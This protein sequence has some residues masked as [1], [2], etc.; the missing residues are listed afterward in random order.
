MKALVYFVFAFETAQTAMTGADMYVWFASGFG[1]LQGLANSGLSPIDIPFFVAF[2][3][4]VVQLFFAYR[5]YTIRNSF[6]PAVI[7]IILLSIMQAGGGFCTGIL[8]RL[9]QEFSASATHSTQVSAGIWLGGTA[10]VDVIIA[11]TMTYLL[12]SARKQE[13]HVS[14][15]ILT[16]IVRLTVETNTVTAI[17]SII[18]IG[19]EYGLPNQPYFYT[20]TAVLGKLYSNT[21]LVTLNN[22]AALRNLRARTP[23]VAARVM[24]GSG[25]TLQGSRSTEGPTVTVES[26]TLADVENGTSSLL[27]IGKEQYAPI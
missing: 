22:R 7:V 25:P 18:T 4:L 16:R 2:I 17:M 11:A 6:W 1:N 3:S 14:S 10:A 21:L 12:L 20:P 26:I 13:H 8:A 19:V 5:I 9:N 24:T 15:D 23:A 27:S